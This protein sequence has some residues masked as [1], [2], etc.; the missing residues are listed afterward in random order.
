V[1]RHVG[2]YDGLRE[3]HARLYAWGK[4]RGLRWQGLDRAKGTE[5]LARF[6]SYLT[7]PATEP[8]PNRL[9]TDVVFLVDDAGS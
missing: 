7:D 3:A 8:D 5:C 2:P 4:E 6:E 9:Q 1:L